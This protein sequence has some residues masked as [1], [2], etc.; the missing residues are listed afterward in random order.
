MDV[1]VYNLKKL[2]KGCVIYRLSGQLQMKKENTAIIIPLTP[3]LVL[4][5]FKRISDE[6]V[7]FMGFGLIWSRPDWMICQSFG[8][9]TPSG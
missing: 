2:K 9:P 7:T 1:G 5:I 6:D 8:C 4:K 3:E